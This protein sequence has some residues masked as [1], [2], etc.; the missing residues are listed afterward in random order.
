MPNSDVFAI[1]Y[2]CIGPAVTLNDFLTFATTAE[3]AIAT[4]DATAALALLPPTA[5][6]SASQS[7]AVGVATD[8]TYVTEHWDS[9][10]IATTGTT[11]LTVPSNGMYLALFN[12]SVSGF[13]TITSS[14]TAININGT[15][16]FAIKFPATA[17]TPNRNTAQGVYRL[18]A[19]DLLRA[20]FTWTGTGGPG[21]VTGTMTIALISRQY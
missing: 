13:T 7:V 8:C 12:L 3:S 15:D 21:T 14:K 6:V 4:V 18:T 10:S 9:G 11:P 17:G 16:Q 2:P 5:G 20:R 19:G 1:T